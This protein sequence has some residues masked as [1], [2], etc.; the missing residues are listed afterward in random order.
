MVLIIY[1]AK[2]PSFPKPTRK[3]NIHSGKFSNPT[4][5]VVHYNRMLCFFTVTCIMILIICLISIFSNSTQ[6]PQ[7]QG[8]YRNSIQYLGFHNALPSTWPMIHDQ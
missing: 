1:L 2:F 8:P 3:Y 5:E 6:D 4:K 7:E